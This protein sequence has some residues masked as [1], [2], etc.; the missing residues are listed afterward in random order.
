VL[1][2]A[3]CDVG[4]RWL[5]R[6]AAAHKK[7]RTVSH[8]CRPHL[9]DT[10][11]NAALIRNDISAQFLRTHTATSCATKAYLEPE[12]LTALAIFVLVT[13]KYFL[14]ITQVDFS[15]YLGTKS[16]RPRFSGSSVTG[17][18]PQAEEHTLN[19]RTHQHTLTRVHTLTH[20]QAPTYAHSYSRTRT[21]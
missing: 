4:F 21:L 1:L 6:A 18:K 19:T 20:A 5:L 15:F 9:P 7:T 2:P 8:D 10:Q 14:N 13:R 17:M 12:S 3:S 11:G 16:H